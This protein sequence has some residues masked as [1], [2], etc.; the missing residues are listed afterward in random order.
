LINAVGLSPEQYSLVFAATSL[1]IMG[2]A[3]LNSRL[4][5][6]GVLP[7]YPLMA[8][9][10][11]AVVSTMVLLAMTLASWMPL[12][13]VISLLDDGHSALSMTAL[14]ALCSLFALASYLLFARP[15]E[16]VAVSS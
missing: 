6:W 9:L 4:S 2:G 16:C 15:P 11:L 14:M 5:V 12:P 10:V 7:G 8:G 13:L 3:F 1:G